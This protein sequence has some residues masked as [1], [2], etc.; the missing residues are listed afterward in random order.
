MLVQ[1]RYPSNRSRLVVPTSIDLTQQLLLKYKL[2]LLILLRILIRPIIFPPHNLPA[3]LTRNIPDHMTTSCHIA[4]AGLAFLDVD[5]A[6][7]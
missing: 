6:V 2:P 5:Y 3:L 7:E 4:F 1:A